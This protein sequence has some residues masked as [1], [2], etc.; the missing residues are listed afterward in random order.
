MFDSYNYRFGDITY[1]LGS[2]T[3]I[4]GVLNVTPDSFSDGGKYDKFEDAVA[5]A[6]VMVADGADFIDIGGRSTRPGSKEIPVEEELNRVIPVI[7]AMKD[8]IDVPIS[9]D[10]YR[11]RVADEV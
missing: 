10:T 11:A 1:D 8:E 7:K 3:Y 9:I 5:H 4:M 6:K 2:R